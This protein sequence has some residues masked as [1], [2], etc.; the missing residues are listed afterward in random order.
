MRCKVT[1]RKLSSNPIH[2]DYQYGLA[3]VLYKRLTTA[4]V[5]L[6][7]ETH[8]NKGFKF[9]TFSNLII[10]NRIPDKNGLNFS[11][12]HFFISSPDNIFIKSFAEGLLM[13][14]EFFL[15]KGELKANFT[16]EKI[17]LLEESAFSDKCIFRTLSPIYVKTQRKKQD[18]LVMVD[19][20]PKEP[21]FYDNLYRNLVNRYEEY[22]KQ[23]LDHYHFDVLDVY[24]VKPKRISVGN[25]QRRCSL[26]TFEVEAN[27]ELLAFAYNAGFGE[28][29]AMGFGCVDIVG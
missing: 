22:Y 3:S 14:P 5:E 1:L 8:R 27:P 6:A 11:K 25:T 20:Y 26:M 29:N 4:N 10:E 17:E 18:K 12:A 13:E 15:G 9:Y 2:Y 28:K 19:L 16:I 24:N 23:S 21:K 7:D